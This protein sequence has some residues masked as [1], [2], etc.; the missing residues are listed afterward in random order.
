M[1]RNTGG[2]D[3]QAEHATAPRRDSMSVPKADDHDDEETMAI[4][5]EMLREAGHV[6]PKEARPTV[7]SSLKA[8]LAGPK[9][10]PLIPLKPGSHKRSRDWEALREVYPGDT[11]GPPRARKCP[12]TNMP[13]MPPPAPPRK[14]EW[15]LANEEKQRAGIQRLCRGLHWAAP[16]QSRVKDR[17]HHAL[18]SLGNVLLPEYH[19]SVL[20]MATNRET[21]PTGIRKQSACIQCQ[22]QAPNQDTLLPGS[23][24]QGSIL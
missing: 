5:D 23:T 17:E 3:T 2:Y 20:Q 13:P 19:L 24:T 16:A 11:A 14:P 22:C 12:V 7:D 10:P 15:I 6:P 21:A 1:H 4:L 8:F 9:E 18:F